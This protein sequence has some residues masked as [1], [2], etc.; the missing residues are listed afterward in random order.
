[1]LSDQMR[2]NYKFKRVSS[3]NYYPRYTSRILIAYYRSTT[4]LE[5]REVIHLLYA[6]ALTGTRTPVTP[7]LVSQTGRFKAPRPN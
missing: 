7:L 3:S 6:P 1:M 4:G 5:K 2:H